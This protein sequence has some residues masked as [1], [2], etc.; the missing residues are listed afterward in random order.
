[1]CPPFLKGTTMHYLFKA[2][3]VV[4][5]I[6][7]ATISG[8]FAQT[9]EEIY[10]SG[11]AAE[12]IVSSSTS[13]TRTLI[14]L[15]REHHLMLARITFQDDADSIK[16][17]I[18]VS[19]DARNDRNMPTSAQRYP[20]Y[21]FSSR[22]QVQQLTDMGSPL[23]RW[24]VYGSYDDAQTLLTKM[25][26]SGFTLT[27]PKLVNRRTLYEYF[28]GSPFPLIMLIGVLLVFVASLVSAAHATRIRAIAMFHG[29]SA[30]FVLARQ[31]Y[32]HG[33]FLAA[34]FGSSWMFWIAL[35]RVLWPQAGI[36]SPSS[37]LFTA[38]VSVSM[39]AAW[40]SMLSGMAIVSLCSR[41]I[42][43]QVKGRRPWSLILLSTTIVLIASLLG[44]S[45]SVSLV[46]YNLRT[47][48]AS[49]QASRHAELAPDGYVMHLWFVSDETRTN[50]LPNW[51]RFI[52]AR[53]AGHSVRVLSYQTHCKWTDASAQSACILMDPDTAQSLLDH[54]MNDSGTTNAITVL[55]PPAESKTAIRNAVRKAWRSESS[56]SQREGKSTNQQPPSI[57]LRPLPSAQDIPLLDS[58]AV[59]SQNMSSQNVPIVIIN[60]VVLSGD[61]M[62]A[63]ASQ[64]GLFFTSSTERQLTQSVHEYGI[65]KFVGWFSSPKNDARQQHSQAV[66]QLAFYTVES[67]LILVTAVAVGVLQAIAYCSLHRQALFVQHLH[68]MPIVLRYR[69]YLIFLALICVTVSA[70]TRYVS[71]V[72]GWILCCFIYLLILAVCA[73][74]AYT[75]DA[76]LRSNMV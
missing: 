47:A 28:L 22:T 66:M 37:Q 68:G 19:D 65:D 14:S 17:V 52:E 35:G 41:S 11:P 25:P 45:S 36:S 30:L 13:D 6:L 50:A 38:M 53:Y 46:T 57:D 43:Q 31:T 73:G 59:I 62:L 58:S 39:L 67:M 23:G 69:S 42:P 7:A 2:A 70:L 49:L 40:S 9:I 64:Q 63:L 18:A 16:R 34:A 60:P 15:V 72:S 54:G 4:T 27:N 55:A 10:P 61:T 75:Y 24:L 20:D 32:S 1:M 56:Q 33:L 74:T 21:G 51:N 8:L 44:L 76:G 12:F 71:T 5:A 48:Q 26:A 29:Q 3:A